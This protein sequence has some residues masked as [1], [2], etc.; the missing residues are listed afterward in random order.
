MENDIMVDTPEKVQIIKCLIRNME[1][2]VLWVKRTC[3]GTLIFT[4]I[5]M[6]LLFFTTT[7][8]WPILFFLVPLLISWYQYQDAIKDEKFLTRFKRDKQGMLNSVD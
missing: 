8:N 7:N 6:T 4:V 1:Q 3:I 5:F 2:R